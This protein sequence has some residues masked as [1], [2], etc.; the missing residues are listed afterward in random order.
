LGDDAN[1]TVVLNYAQTYNDRFR[2][3]NLEK[4]LSLTALIAGAAFV[5]LGIFL[6]PPDAPQ[7]GVRVALVPAGNGMGLAVTFP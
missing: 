5:G 6:I 3:I 7:T 2:V 4:T 1:T